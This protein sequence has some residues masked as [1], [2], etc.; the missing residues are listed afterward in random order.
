MPFA[1]TLVTQKATAVPIFGQYAYTQLPRV[2]SGM[3]TDKH[4]P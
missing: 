2:G 4:S 1:L 3:Y